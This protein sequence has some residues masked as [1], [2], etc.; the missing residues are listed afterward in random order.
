[1]KIL[2]QICILTIFSVQIR[3]EYSSICVC[4][5]ISDSEQCDRS[6]ICQW[7]QNKC[8]IKNGE[9][10]LDKGTVGAQCKEYSQEDCRLKDKCGFY[11]GE[12]IE[13]KECKA[14]KREECWESSKNCISDGMKCIDVGECEEYENWIACQN[15]NKANRYCFWSI[16]EN[17]KCRVSREC[18]EL[19]MYLISDSECRAQI[20]SCTVSL[21][22]GCEES[23]EHCKMIKYQEQCFYNKAKSK[24]CYWD[25]ELSACVDLVCDNLR[26]TT[27]E[28]CRGLLLECTTNGQ[29]CVLRKQ[30]QDS[31]AMEGC[32]T[33][34]Y[35]NNCIFM[36]NECK[37]KECS[38][39][40]DVN[41]YSNYNQC[42][43]FDSHLDCVF[44]N[45]GGCKTRPIYCDGYDA[46]EDCLSNP[47]QQCYWINAQNKCKRQGCDSQLSSLNHNQCK[48]VGKCMG[49][50]NG[51]CQ[52]RPITCNLINDNQFCDVDYSNRKCY[53]NSNQCVENICSNFVFPGFTDHLQCNTV[54]NKC[55]YDYYLGTCRDQTC[56]IIHQNDCLTN[57]TC[58]LP[59]KCRLKQCSDAP[60]SFITHE[61]CEL[62]LKNCTVNVY[63]IS[64]SQ[65]IHG[66]I[67][68]LLNCNDFHQQQCYQTLDGY[69]CK[70]TGAICAPSVCS[71]FITFSSTF[72][73]NLKVVGMKCFLDSVNSKCQ[74]WPNVCSGISDL[75][76]CTQG[77]PDGT[78][79]FWDGTSCIFKA[80]SIPSGIPN[81]YSCYQWNP[82][83]NYD[84]STSKCKQRDAL[85][86]CSMTVT[87]TAQTHQEC[88]A[89]NKLCTVNT[90]GAIGCQRK[91]YQCPSYTDQ[92]K[93]VHDYYGV[94]CEWDTVNSLCDN[95]TPA[96][97]PMTLDLGVT[98]QLCEQISIN[99]VNQ[100]IAC[101]I[102]KS[103]CAL[104]TFEMQCKINSYYEPC[105]WNGTTCSSQQCQSQ[106]TAN[107]DSD[108]FKFFNSSRNCQL[109]IKADGTRDQGCEIMGLCSS[110]TS[111]QKCDVSVSKNEVSC[112]FIGGVCQ[113]VPQNSSQDCHLNGSA[114]SNYECKQI[115]DICELNYRDGVGCT[116]KSC[117]LITNSSI[118]VLQKP[119]G[120]T[121]NWN[122]S[123]NQC[124]T[125]PCSSYTTD[126]NCILAYENNNI[127]CFWCDS[128]C[129]NSNYCEEVLADYHKECNNKNQLYTIAQLQTC[130]FAQNGCSTYSASSSC[131]FTDNR[132]KCFFYWMTS[133]TA[134]PTT[135][136]C[137]ELCPIHST[138][139]LCEQYSNYCYWTS[140]ACISVLMNCSDYVTS[141][142]E[143]SLIRNGTRCTIDVSAS[144][145]QRVCSNYRNGA[146]R[147]PS[148]QSDCDN[149]LDNC[150]FSGNKC[151]D[152]CLFATLSSV[153]ITSCEQ[154]KANKVCTIGE[155]PKCGPFVQY[156]SQAQQSQCY[157]SATNQKCYWNSNLSQ[158]FEL[159]ACNILDNLNNNHTKC[160]SLLNICT[161]NELR[162]GCIELTDCPNYTKSYQ[163]I[164][165]RN[166]YPC[167]WKVDK[168]IT[169]ECN[170]Y[171]TESTCEN[172]TLSDKCVWDHINLKCTLL[173]CN[174]L[175]VDQT[176]LCSDYTK[177]CINESCKTVECEDY[178]YGDEMQ[179]Q[180]LFP[181]KHC[182]SDGQTC[183]QRL[184]CHD[185]HQQICCNFDRTSNDCIWIS[186]QCYDR[187]C[188]QMPIIPFTLDECISVQTQCTLK[189]QGGCQLKTK[190]SSYKYE[191]ECLIDQ[192]GDNCVWEYSLQQCFSDM[193]QPI[194]GDGVVT[195]PFEECDDTNNLPYDG[196]YE[197]K[198]QCSFGC[199][200]CEG[201]VCLKCNPYGW[202]RN[203][204]TQECDSIC[205]DG[206]ITILEKCDDGNFIQFDGCYEC[207]YQCS[208][209]CLNCYQ[210]ICWECLYG[211]Y[212][213]NS[214]CFAQCGD[215][216]VIEEKEE[217]D[218]GN[219][220][221]HD[222]CNSK[223]QVETN[224]KC[225]IQNQLS[226]CIQ[227]D[228]PLPLLQM[229][230]HKPTYLSFT[231]TQPVMLSESNYNTLD[232]IKSIQISISGLDKN[233]FNFTL[234]PI[235]QLSKELKDI[236]YTID[237][238]FQISIK[239]PILNLTFN[240]DLLVNE[241]GN[242][243]ASKVTLK[244]SNIEQLT[245]LQ[246]VITDTAAYFNSIV[247]YILIGIA[248]LSFFLGNFEIFWN[249]LDNL[250]QLS[251]IKYINI[252]YPINFSIFLAI[253]DLVSLQPLYDY[254]YIDSIFDKVMQQ[255]TPTIQYN[256]GKFEFFQTDCFFGT[257][258]QGFIIILLTSAINY[259][260]SKI[261]IQLLIKSKYQNV[262][263]QVD[264]SVR[265]LVK[266]LIELLHSIESLALFY[267]KSF[268]YQGLIRVFLS[269]YYDLT[270]SSLL[271]IVTF[272]QQSRLLQ[273][274]SA[275]SV[276]IFSFNLL[277]ILG[278]Y[279]YSLISNKL[280][281]TVKSNLFFEG[282]NTK[283]N[284][285]NAQYQTILLIK[286]L[287]F[288]CTLVLFQVMPACQT[289]FISFQSVI[290]T[291]YIL[292][293]KPMI[294]S[295]ENFK[296]MVFETSIYINSILFLCHDM[297][298]FYQY[299]IQIGW[300]NIT[301]FSVNL[302][303]C[304]IVDIYQQFKILKSKLCKPVSK[305]KKETNPN[306]FQMC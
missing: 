264:T 177:Y 147:Q 43:Q 51:G 47:A 303:C 86:T 30:C 2:R 113:E 289:L 219:L 288:I 76:L 254:L 277:S 10:Y 121:C 233:Q 42:Q 290:F 85:D 151:V 37:K 49:K 174:T 78:K 301:L 59:K 302:I 1:M 31:L 92:S 7:I 171:V 149:W 175:L 152:A 235:T 166:H 280:I 95:Y 178:F 272:S 286:K 28:E 142:C 55:T 16:N 287:S 281:Q 180:Q 196:C 185:C 273:I 194:C 148:N 163:C 285:W 209:E 305:A 143:N 90:S 188:N 145:V 193:C 295:F 107:N 5:Q 17:P 231:F 66:C 304:L 199:L 21:D 138:Q 62:W 189:A 217:C 297:D 238:S 294:Q 69:Q 191:S 261:M 296:I 12:C 103:D 35:G 87:F 190:C 208:F 170:F 34:I 130:A 144:C 200:I 167:F 212:P 36:N 250:Q 232:F 135:G 195:Y 73:D 262:I 223:C 52:D 279:S 65:Q 229:I 186:G 155:E 211:F 300:V 97:C 274:C 244:L 256:V 125:N 99:C 204:I 40:E 271:Q 205:G 20:S 224:W 23:K 46:Q 32:V 93:C 116:A 80:C 56:E 96:T 283:V 263:N 124:E 298:Y 22:G 74:A 117:N 197:C 11:L 247:L 267:I 68:K 44:K 282:I 275:L 162:N 118:C 157:Q 104:Y 54:N 218:D 13:F 252:N 159:N 154:Y 4:S 259:K 187:I 179:C 136:I 260:L 14:F 248:V 8:L 27:D 153:S 182:T 206:I 160:Y 106:T 70:W 239:N 67:Q 26:F 72:C 164:L 207:D 173:D 141:E 292:L 61:D 64:G 71:D 266:K 81:N 6:S 112:Q 158:C 127:K 278:F 306:I 83:C 82:I 241:L 53:W 253:F 225:I 111:Q 19:P 105:V 291:L 215:G 38:L 41:I 29:V 63:Q 98:N 115:N 94:K 161:V 236:Q 101:E 201:K 246:K 293:S 58:K 203:N 227:Q 137:T 210:G 221:D 89:W 77:L 284:K 276:A 198:I 102:L 184:N 129:I 226:L 100:N 214:F 243:P 269:S 228:Y 213:H 75:T 128:R 126:A 255:E 57:P 123:L 299:R 146:S 134:V 132:T 18:K 183:L 165:N 234:T 33:D 139:A 192:N 251:Y 258:F 131:K 15:M 270:F 109:K 140:G 242:N 91:Q 120:A 114:V 230:N 156:C 133:G 3:G 237:L 79:C 220:N 169:I 245:N 84:I 25:Q 240:Q 110:I 257:N 150:V 222:G 88:N 249:L 122:S 108:C 265:C 176:H 168:C 39:A 45:G 50:L 172:A 181:D 216:I 9:T 119:K 268:F 24:Q 48:L 60:V 202:I